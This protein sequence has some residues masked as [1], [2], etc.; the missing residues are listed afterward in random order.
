MR[1]SGESVMEGSVRSHLP[2]IVTECGDHG[3]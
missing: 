2:D 3:T 1:Q